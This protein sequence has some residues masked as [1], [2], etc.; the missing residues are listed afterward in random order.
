MTGQKPSLKQLQGRAARLA[1]NLDAFA[2]GR[3]ERERWGLLESEGL[4]FC[5][6]LRILDD[7][8]LAD[9][10]GKVDE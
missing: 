3:L 1:A 8:D 5:K 6:T 10:D 9:V 4:S 7:W 2:A